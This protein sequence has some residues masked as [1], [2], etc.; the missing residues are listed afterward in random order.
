MSPFGHV[1]E[2]VVDKVTQRSSG[3]LETSFFY[4]NST[5]VG[6][7]N[8]MQAGR[9]ASEASSAA[10]L[11]PEDTTLVG[12]GTRHTARI[13]Q[14]THSMSSSIIVGKTKMPH[15]FMYNTHITR[16]KD[17]ATAGRSV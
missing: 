11:V 17:G 6:D 13:H 16:R 15:E 3:V 5:V 9:Y 2:L 7:S 14:R 8:L 1:T 10:L 4:L 12:I